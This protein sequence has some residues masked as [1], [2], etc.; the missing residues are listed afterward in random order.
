[1][2][3]LGPHNVG[4]AVRMH[5]S[6]PLKKKRGKEERNSF[7]YVL[8][9]FKNNKSQNKMVTKETKLKKVPER[10]FGRNFCRVEKLGRQ[11]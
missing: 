4:A 7:K 11:H 9:S 2:D 6:T 5:I 10:G 3:L 1:M 8:R